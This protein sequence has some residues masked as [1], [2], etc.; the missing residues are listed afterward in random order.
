MGSDCASLIAPKSQHCVG[1]VTTPE[2]SRSL[3]TSQRDDKT[4]SQSGTR[5]AL[6]PKCL[7][8][9]VLITFKKKLEH[10]VVRIQNH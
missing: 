8:A 1:D 9:A 2:W 3:T 5:I 10:D 4:P 7:N 6:T